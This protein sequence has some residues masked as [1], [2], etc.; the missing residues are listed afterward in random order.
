[1]FL[2]IL[3]LIIYLLIIVSIIFIERKNS[4]EAVMWVLIVT[5]VPYVGTILYLIF[6]NTVN[7]KIVRFLREKRL[8]N[9]PDTAKDYYKALEQA[10]N[11]SLDSCLS[12]VD[13]RVAVFNA[14][15]NQ[16]LLTTFDD[17]RFLISGKA[18]YEKL[19]RDIAEAEKSIHI[20]FFT[21]HPDEVG[22]AFISA[23][24][25]KAGEGVNVTLICDFFA[26]AGTPEKFFKP[27]INAGGYVKRV[28]RS[29]THFRSHRKIVTIDEKIA[30]IGGMNIGRQYA[31]LAKAKS[32]W[33]DTQIRLTGACVG[34]LENYINLDTVCS[35]NKK[36]YSELSQNC[37]IKEIKIENNFSNACQFV[38][39]GADSDKECI[40]M[41]YLSM[42][43]NAA[44]SIRIQSPYFVP[45]TSLLDELKAACAS[46][47]RVEIMIPLVKSSFFLKPVSD[48]YAAS[49]AEYGAHIYKYK[50]YIHAKTLIIDDELCC[51]GSVNI[52]VR[53]L[54]IDDEICGI[55]YNNT[56]TKKY[57]EIYD[58]DIMNCESFDLNAFSKRSR[59][60]KV[61]EKFLLLF[62]PLM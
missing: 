41:C 35:M 9:R 8:A 3:L 18:H 52:D 15:Y 37:K 44:K 42:M 31:D 53:S 27:L 36:E 26:N 32:P 24:S 14:A 38:M 55:F 59:F 22:R 50:G 39:G 7:I 54:E 13:E 47:V 2:K 28:K 6:G 45:D 48:F 49:L 21:V 20:E 57:S 46:G 56:L 58:N 51:V 30:Y 61:K 19:F 60:E 40:K 5:A 23:L 16:S 25:K 10:K 12:E 29:L 33:R 11:T 17:A 4:Q 1:M 62:A 43:R 34:V